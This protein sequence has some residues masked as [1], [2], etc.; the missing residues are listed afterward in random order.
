MTCDEFVGRAKTNPSAIEKM[1]ID[2]VLREKRR[3]EQGSIAS[4]TIRN[5]LKPIKLLLEM[6]NA[7]GLNWNKILPNAYD[8]STI[9]NIMD[10][11][12]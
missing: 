8:G 10:R 6:N 2:F 5:K 4:S 3:L 12:I 7:I 11:S 1:V 9:Y